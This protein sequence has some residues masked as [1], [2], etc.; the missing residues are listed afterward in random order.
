MEVSKLLVIHF[1]ALVIVALVNIFAPEFIKNEPFLSLF[2]PIK[3]YF[4]V[5]RISLF[6]AA[7]IVLVIMVPII[8]YRGFPESNLK[9]IEKSNVCYLFIAIL[10]IPS[11]W[12]MTLSVGLCKVCYTANDFIYLFYILSVFLGFQFCIQYAL[13][14]FKMLILKRSRG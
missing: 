3:E 2:Y 13:L 6:A 4:Y 5:Y 7:T 11:V 10:G 12:F 9:G 8:A 1:F 14:R